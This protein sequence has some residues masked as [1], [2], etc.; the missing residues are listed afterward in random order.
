MRSLILLLGVSGLVGLGCRPGSPNALPVPAYDPEKMAA[1][2][3]RQYDKNGNGVLESAELEACPALKGALARFDTDKDG[4]ISA[5]ELRARFQSYKVLGTGAMA[6]GVEVKMGGRPLEGAIV[7]F[8]PEDC[9]LDAI[10]GGS[11]YAN[12]NGRVTLD[13]PA[14]VPGLPCGLYR[15]TVSKKSPTGVESVP[16]KYNTATTLGREISADP[17]S[18]DSSI[19]LDLK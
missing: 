1:A 15:I 6:V 11:G 17:R 19:I 4:A 5:D 9:M 18:G 2:A 8:T 12:V 3:L 14:G 7:T 16:A 10:S 13:G